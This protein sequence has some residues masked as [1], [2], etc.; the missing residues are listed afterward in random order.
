[1][2]VHFLQIISS[3]FSS[4]VFA[5]LTFERYLVPDKRTDIVSF[6]IIKKWNTKDNLR[7]T[8]DSDSPLHS[9]HTEGTGWWHCQ[10]EWEEYP[11]H[12]LNLGHEE[13]QIQK[14]F[15]TYICVEQ[16]LQLNWSEVKGPASSFD[17]SLLALCFWKENFC[18]SQMINFF[19]PILVINTTV[20]PF[21]GSLDF[22]A[23]LFLQKEYFCSRIPPHL[24]WPLLY[25]RP[26]LFIKVPRRGLCLLAHSCC[27]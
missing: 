3:Y 2:C 26:S 22:P 11:C 12:S 25:T 27:I 4:L 19:L 7:Y 10:I 6:L 21:K 16:T 9:I 24:C 13:E 17:A 8:G 23:V 15:D 1:M 14:V 18:P 20:C 5:E